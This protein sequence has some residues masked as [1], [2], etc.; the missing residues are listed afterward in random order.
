MMSSIRV[1]SDHECGWLPPRLGSLLGFSGELRSDMAEG[2]KAGQQ[3]LADCTLRLRLGVS[4][5]AI[6]REG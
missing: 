3:D 1:T 4:E 2:A 5:E 6:L